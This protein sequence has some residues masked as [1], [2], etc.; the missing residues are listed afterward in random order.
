MTEKTTYDK[1]FL[2]FDEQIKKLKDDYNLKIPNYNN[3]ILLLKD[4]SYYDL[5]NGYKN[6]F[7]KD[8]KYNGTLTIE[9]L[10]YFLKYDK[11]IQNVLLKY[12]LYV[13]NKFKNILAYVLSLKYG[14]D[15]D[16]YLDPANFRNNGYKI[17]ATIDYIKYRIKNKKYPNPTKHYINKHNH[18]PA[19]I[20]LRNI[21]FN[22]AIDIYNNLFVEDKKEVIKLISNDLSY[23]KNSI[24]IF[25]NSI[26]IVRKFRNVIA[27]NYDFINERTYEK[28]IRHQLKDSKYNKLITYEDYKTNLPDNGPYSMVIAISL[29]MDNYELLNNLYQELIG[30]MY[31][32]SGNPNLY[33]NITETY[34]DIGGIPYDIDQR[35][36]N[37]INTLE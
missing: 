22:Q 9:D 34:F 1:P 30:A 8:S 10:Y 15:V 16:L 17:N 19:W 31:V 33:L 7:M 13:E 29:I 20:L 26:I 12:A 5:I 2:T 36:V 18:I 4:I 25:K 35:L 24:S 32:M 21:T 23:N 28:I 11:N 37:Q 6:C 3:A 14:V 27:H